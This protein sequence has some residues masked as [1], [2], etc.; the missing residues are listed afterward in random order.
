VEKVTGEDKKKI[1]ILICWKVT[2]QFS[3]CSKFFYL[4]S[5]FTLHLLTAMTK[6]ISGL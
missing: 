5:D 2:D 4:T 6:T 3:D 1:S